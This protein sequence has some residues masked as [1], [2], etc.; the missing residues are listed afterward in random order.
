MSGN[1]GANIS[2]TVKNYGYK[3]GV[4]TALHDFFV[5]KDEAEGSNAEEEDSL[6]IGTSSDGSKTIRDEGSDDSVS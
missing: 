5:A 1:D 3:N 4:A 2:I 6:D